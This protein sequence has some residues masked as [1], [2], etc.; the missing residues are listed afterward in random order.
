[1]VPGVTTQYLFISTFNPFD[2]EPLYGTLE[3]L[4]LGNIN[5][6]S[7]QID[8][9][10]NGYRRFFKK[11]GSYYYLMHLDNS[12]SKA[13]YIKKMSLIISNNIPSF[14]VVKSNRNV[15]VSYQAMISCDFTKDNNYF[16]CAYF[17][18]NEL[19]V[20]ISVFNIELS[21]IYS[22]E[23]EK[24]ENFDGADNFIK[25]VYLKD[26][27]DFILMN[28]END[29]ITRLRYFNYKYNS[30][31]DKLSSI[32]KSSNTYL[33]IDYTQTHKF[34]GFNDIIETIKLMSLCIINI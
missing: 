25:I 34:N 6:R 21:E 20:K 3:I 2:D 22:K 15:K 18:E 29:Q 5:L 17:S 30:I 10:I 9:S 28:S 23:F 13:L 26:N 8:Y 12:D 24:V 32:T 33:N 11:A 27:S 4:D 1:M 19:K 7:E 14:Q 31:T 16:L